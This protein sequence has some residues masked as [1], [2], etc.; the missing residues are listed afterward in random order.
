VLPRAAYA[1]VGVL[2]VAAAS[3]AVPALFVVGDRWALAVTTLLVVALD[4]VATVRM[5]REVLL[6]V[7]FPVAIAALIVLGPW[8]AAFASLACALSHQ[9][10][11]QP[12]LKRVF[13]G[14]Q[15]ALSA[16]CAGLVYRWL[17]GPSELSTDVFPRVLGVV[18]VT[19]TVYAVVNAALV[20]GAL[21][22]AERR[23]FGTAWWSILSQGIASYLGYSAF[24][25]MMAALWS[26]DVGL[27]AAVLVLLPLLVARW[28]FAQYAEQREAHDRTVRTL[29]QAVETKDYY[30][31]GHSERVS[32]GS[33]MIA[34]ALGMTEG[35]V[36]LVRFAGLLHDLGKLGVPTRLLQKPGALTREEFEAVKLHP[37]RGVEI[38]REIAFLREAFDGI[39]HHH[40][41]VDGRG[42]PL[43][44]AGS[45]IP[46][47][48]RVIAV[49][50][51]FDSMTS[52]RAY[53]GAKPTDEAIEELRRCKGT[54]FDP[55]MVDAFVDA[56]AQHGWRPS[57]VAPEAPV[58]EA[59]V[60]RY[61]HDDPTRSVPVI[62]EGKS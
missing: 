27:L 48:A 25:L 8:A 57:D 17:G 19:A 35:R 7:I 33:E 59:A 6:S 14:A 55:R 43:G 18:A 60:T 5:Q 49:A 56:V 29:I 11:G 38:V 28:A 23:P 37:V 45:A 1:Y 36:E 58:P 34:R 16:V 42:Y 9:P 4:S 3:S 51:A 46:E 41:R 40:E 50:D 44:L 52:A 30:T 54:Y 26:S 13:N 2:A 22:A 39:M 61:D 21:R 32:R 53:R 20:A 10:G 15:L 12:V 31:R 24:G 62:G 47:F